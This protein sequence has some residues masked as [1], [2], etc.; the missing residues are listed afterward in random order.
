MPYYEKINTLF[1]HVP[2]TGGSSLENYLKKKSPQTV[3]TQRI[4]N[5]LPE[6]RYHNKSL[7]HQFYTVLYQYRDLLRI[8]FDSDLKIITIVRNPY[9]RAVSDL[10]Y[11]KLVKLTDSQEAFCTALKW[12][13]QS[14]EYDNH[15]V[16]QNMLLTDDLGNLV[17]GIRIFKTET[18]VEDLKAYGF[19]DYAG[20]GSGVDYMK[21]MNSEFISIVN[22]VY[23]RDFDLFGYRRLRS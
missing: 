10:V 23:Q 13:L 7:Q 8:K 15:Q 19:T 11:N 14:D 21:Y 1:I 12:F 5:I 9:S 20:T 3:Y 17:D 22:Q 2:R 16:P 4:N 18:L 6:S